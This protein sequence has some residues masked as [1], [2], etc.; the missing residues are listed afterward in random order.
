MSYY[1]AKT[2]FII[3]NF[4]ARLGIVDIC[5]RSY[6]HLPIHRTE[7]CAAHDAIPLISEPYPVVRGLSPQDVAHSFGR[8]RPWC[9]HANDYWPFSISVNE[10]I[11]GRHCP[12]EGDKHFRLGDDRINR[13]CRLFVA[14]DRAIELSSNGRPRSN[15]L[16]PGSPTSESA[17]HAASGY[18]RPAGDRRCLSGEQTATVRNK[19][20]V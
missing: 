20:T 8:H 15:Q 12:Q 13:R 1:N 5:Q 14:V 19:A 2:L 7:N 9:S 16:R 4:D 6:R 11:V 18:R 17:I 10:S 3:I